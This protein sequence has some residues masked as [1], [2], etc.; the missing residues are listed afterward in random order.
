MLKADGRFINNELLSNIKFTIPYGNKKYRE[1]D[2]WLI[3]IQNT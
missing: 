3:N 1:S 2:N